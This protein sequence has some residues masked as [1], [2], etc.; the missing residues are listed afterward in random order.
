MGL[1]GE[2]KSLVFHLKDGRYAPHVDEA[3]AEVLAGG[4]EE[5][6]EG[7]PKAER[8]KEELRQ[9]IVILETSEQ[10]SQHVNVKV[11]R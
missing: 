1:M 8:K 11:I 4:E 6:E 10:P 2:I 9:K 7:N 5:G 3:G